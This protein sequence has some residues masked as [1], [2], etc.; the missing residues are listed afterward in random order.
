MWNTWDPIDVTWNCGD[1][2]DTGQWS[3]IRSYSG[4][5]GC[6]VAHGM[7]WTVRRHRD[8]LN[9][10]KSA[11][12]RGPPQVSS[13]SIV[14]YPRFCCIRIHK[15]QPQVQGPK[16]TKSCQIR[17]IQDPTSAKSLKSRQIRS[18][19]PQNQGPLMQV[20]GQRCQNQ[21][22]SSHL[23]SARLPKSAWMDPNHVITASRTLTSWWQEDT[24]HQVPGPMSKLTKVPPIVDNS[25][26]T[27]VDFPKVLQIVPTWRQAFLWL[28]NSSATS[29]QRN[30]PCDKSSKIVPK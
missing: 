27:N 21:P 22:W 18:L 12:M 16:P 8:L 11:L 2:C 29:Y 7:P 5:L 17:R 10:W 30:P 13:S 15:K 9:Q 3:V 19:E 26:W 25:S 14:S 24:W 1:V 28:S 6:Y 4:P 20:Q 23:R